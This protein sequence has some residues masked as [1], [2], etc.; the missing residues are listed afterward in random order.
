MSGL[1][2]ARAAESAVDTNQWHAIDGKL[3][4]VFDT[5]D[6]NAGLIFAQSIGQAADA[7][8]HHPDIDL[9]Y[10]SVRVAIVSHDVAGLTDRD[11]GLAKTISQIAK[12]QGLAPSKIVASDITIAIDT[13][14]AEAIKP[15]WRAAL[16]LPADGDD[17]EL[18]D[19][20]GRLPRVWFQR[21][22]GTRTD[23]NRIHLD[24]YVPI[25]LAQ[26]RVLHVLDAGGT[27]I[28]D[29]FAPR[30]W[31]IAD[32]DGNEVCICTDVGT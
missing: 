13:A 25:P 2:T 6:F 8:N 21:S 12:D 5:K 7:A 9:R 32:A 19:P 26:D 27:L 17:E 3:Q 23:R 16:G 11:T 15:F 30:W 10:G 31:V 4:A 18:S 29:E 28:T 14:D 24:I 1:I 20:L 22:D